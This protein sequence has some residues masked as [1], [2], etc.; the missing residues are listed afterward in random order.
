MSSNDQTFFVL[1]EK[2]GILE[3]IYQRK[4]KEINNVYSRSF[5][6]NND[7]IYFVTDNSIVV[8]TYKDFNFQFFHLF[9][10]M[11]IVR[12]ILSAKMVL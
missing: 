6:I 3:I 1:K 10:F 11:E 9:Q 7:K 2:N 4:I 8:A 12:L 5:T